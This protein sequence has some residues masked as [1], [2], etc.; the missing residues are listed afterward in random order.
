MSQTKLIVLGALFTSLTVIFQMVPVFFSEAFVLVTMLSALPIYMTA[1]LDP[2]IGVAGYITAAIL[3]TLFSTHE[4]LFFACANGVVGL[5]LGV[6][7][8]Y[9][10]KKIIIISIAT[11]ALTFTLSTVT[12]VIG[13]P[14][15]GFV[16]NTSILIQIAILLIFSLLYCMFYFYISNMVF[17]KIFLS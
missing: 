7:H 8:F 4:G 14:V 17:R 13:I 12:F 15:F 1:K 16:M 5:A 9:T 6:T 2:K 10:N 3:I 11:V